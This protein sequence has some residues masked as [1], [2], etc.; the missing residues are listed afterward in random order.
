MGSTLWRIVTVDP[1]EDVVEAD[2]SVVGRLDGTEG[3][4]R[5]GEEMG[6]W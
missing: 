6:D 3:E 5:R 4:L 1:T 2:E